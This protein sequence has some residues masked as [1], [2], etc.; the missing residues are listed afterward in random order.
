MDTSPSPTGTD[1]L[2]SIPGAVAYIGMGSNQGNRLTFL[3]QAHRVIAAYSGIHIEACSDIYE[4][5]SVEGGGP[6][7]FLNAVIRIRTTLSAPDLLIALQRIESAFGRPDPPRNGPRTIDLDVL[8]YD[9][10][11]ID[12][13]DLAV[14]HPRLPYRLFV[15]R[16][17]CDVLLGGWVHPTGLNL[18]ETGDSEKEINTITNKSE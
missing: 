14:P 6:T 8:L 2:D 1:T 11:T 10:E 16:P 15:L 18:L 17:L 7:N 3:R 13:V 9:E 4:S 12:T 5:E